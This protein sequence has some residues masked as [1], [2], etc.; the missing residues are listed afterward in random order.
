[1]T[2]KFVTEVIRT[3]RMTL[4]QVVWRMLRRQPRGYVERVL[5]ANQDLSLQTPFLTVGTVV[6]LPLEDVDRDE[7]TQAPVVRLWD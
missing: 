5:E 2:E 3:E 6:K 1:M 7:A 4:S